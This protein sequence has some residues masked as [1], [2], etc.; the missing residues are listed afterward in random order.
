MKVVSIYSYREFGCVNCGFADCNIN[1]ESRSDVHFYTC[2]ECGANFFAVADYI[3]FINVRIDNKIV[4]L[5]KEEHPRYGTP[6][7]GFKGHANICLLEEKLSNEATF[8]FSSKT[9]AKNFKKLIDKACNTKHSTNPKA[10]PCF[11]CGFDST[12]IIET[13]SEKNPYQVKI[14][15]CDKHRRYLNLLVDTTQ[16]KFN[17]NYGKI[18][19]VLDTKWDYKKIWTYETDPLIVEF[20]NDVDYE[21]EETLPNDI[22]NF[23]ALVGTKEAVC[24]AFDENDDELAIMAIKHYL[25]GLH[26]DYSK[27]IKRSLQEKK[28]FND[29]EKSLKT[30]LHYYEKEKEME[31]GNNLEKALKK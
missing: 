2:P 30:V 4:L 25:V 6:S 21:D 10:T 19:E 3:E 11:V 7:H 13:N 23:C 1:D 27:N 26:S 14:E 18:K 31:K 5:K 22:L 9:A 28:T 29:I 24:K 16:R 17:I 8:S 12:T 20:S 15:T